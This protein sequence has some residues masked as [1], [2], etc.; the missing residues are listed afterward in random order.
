MF[1]HEFGDPK[2]LG[3]SIGASKGKA[4]TFFKKHGRRGA[5]IAAAAI[6]LLLAVRSTVAE[7]FYVSSGCVAPALPEG[8]RCLVYKLA[9]KFRQGDLIVYRPAD[10]PDHR[11]L[12]VVESV[13]PSGDLVVRRNHSAVYPIDRSTVV[14][15][16]VLNTR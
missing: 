1:S 15:R 9:S 3:Q 8:S 7:A 11:Y 2:S 12:A 10:A 4:R 16:V 14:G 5:I 13:S 6:V